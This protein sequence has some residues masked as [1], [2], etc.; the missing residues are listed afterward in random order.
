MIDLLYQ[1]PDVGKKYELP[2]K[3]ES[4]S[5]AEPH[6]RKDD[7]DTAFLCEEGE[8]QEAAGWSPLTDELLPPENVTDV[9]NYD[10]DPKVTQAVA[11]IPP[12]SD[13]VEMQDV[14][15]PL[16]FEPEVSHTRYNHNLVQASENPG[17]WPN[18]PVTKREDR[19]LDED[20]QAK[21]SGNGKTGSRWKCQ[22]PYHQEVITL[23][24]KSPHRSVCFGSTADILSS[25]GPYS[26]LLED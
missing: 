11:N 4:S 15:A 17:L 25:M 3:C 5:Q 13:D 14:S 12:R 16:G 21:A 7:E 9:L 20:P 10:E 23:W 6:Q 22:S 18:S 19:M 24:G 26:P 2:Q 8:Q 1:G